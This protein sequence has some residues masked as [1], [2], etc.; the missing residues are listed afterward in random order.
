MLRGI[1]ALQGRVWSEFLK[2]QLDP[3]KERVDERT[4]ELARAIWSLGSRL[5]ITTNY[6]KVLSWACP[7]SNLEIWGIQNKA[8]LAAV[9]DGSYGRFVLWHLHGSIA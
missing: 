5:V 2:Q 6:D 9:C 8:E 1:T 4:L 7:Y 3:D